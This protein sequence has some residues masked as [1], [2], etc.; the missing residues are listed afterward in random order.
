MSREKNT[1]HN[2]KMCPHLDSESIATEV[3]E[4]STDFEEDEVEEMV[5]QK[6]EVR[7]EVKIVLPRFLLPESICSPRRQLRNKIFSTLL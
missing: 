7:V 4:Q 2:P 5:F 6:C 3:M 1:I